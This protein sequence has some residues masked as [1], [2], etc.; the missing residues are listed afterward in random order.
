MLQGEDP[1]E[2]PHP[3]AQVSERHKLV[4]KDRDSQPSRLGFKCSPNA[5]QPAKLAT[6]LKPF[7]MAG[8][9]FATQGKSC[10]SHT[11]GGA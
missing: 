3:L 7:C 6:V 9:S 2:D 5:Y 1:G 10:C 4:V 11:A 8:S